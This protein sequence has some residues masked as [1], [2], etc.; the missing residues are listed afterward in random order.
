[1]GYDFSVHLINLYKYY[2]RKMKNINIIAVFV[3]LFLAAGI[4]AA[5]KNYVVTKD[6]SGKQMIIGKLSWKEWQENAGW[7]NYTPD[8]YTPDSSIIHKLSNII[9][10][11]NIE[12]LLFGGSWCGDSKTEMPKIY[13]LFNTTGINEER[14][15]LFGVN[16]EKF[17]FS[18]ES[19]KYNI[20]KV[21]TLIILRNGGEAG[22]IVEFP[23][24]SWE[25]DIL[26]ILQE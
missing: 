6:A 1:V 7:Q 2:K 13:Y 15:K 8:I 12:F 18:G 10:S 26:M 14:V 24:K 21:P 19:I 23:Q 17:E 9:H 11:Q 20:K 22:R 3:I 25:A 4:P 16:R 5:A